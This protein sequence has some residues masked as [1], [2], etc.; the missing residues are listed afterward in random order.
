MTKTLLHYFKPH[1]KIFAADMFCAVMIALIDLVFPYVSRYS[2]YDLLPAMKYKAFFVVMALM[3]AAFA[4]RSG[5]YYIMTYWGHT[6]GVL[7][8]TDI[9]ADLFHHMQELD[10]EF[11]D[12]NRTG[13]LMSRLTSDLFDIT[14]LAHHGPEDI[15]ISLC[16]IAGSLV[17]MFMMEWRLALVI[18][19]L[20]PIF[21]IVLMT[22]RRDMENTSVT[23]KKKQAVISAEIES[24]I[25]GIRTSK[26]FANEEVDEERFDDSNTRYGRAKS[27]YYKAM[28]RFNASQ[29]FFM[30]AIQVAVIAFGG[31]LI[32]QEKMNYIDLITFMLY[33]STFV[34]P[35]RRLSNLADVLTNGRAGLKRFTEIMKIQPEIREKEDAKPLVVT[36]G[37][38]DIDDVTFS[39]NGKT[40]VIKDMTLH[41]RPGETLAIVG[42]SGGGKTT[43]CQL[44]PRFY[45]VDKGSIRIDGTDIRDVTKRSIRENVGIVQQD[46]FIFA[47]TVRENIRY[48]RPEATEEEI[49]EAARRAEIYDDIMRMPD[50]FDTY[51]GERG[52]KLS[53]GQKQRISIARIFLKDPK[54]LILDEATSSLDTITERAIQQSFDELAKGR[55]SLVIA[56]RLATVINA[57]RIV[58]IDDGRIA[59]EGTHRELMALNGEYARLYNTQKLYD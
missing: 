19:I 16:T 14:E 31:A 35:I 26:A 8:E 44:I 23:V 53:G 15:V 11:Y 45:D 25:S 48:G 57:D 37:A 13:V 3:V 32:M 6:F 49:D 1:K 33:I 29:E 41:V 36:D 50:G 55:T 38:I 59:E 34:T 56:H 20:V 4:M 39:Y 30:C 46:V 12:Q 22:S 17:F 43:L 52:T 47:D 40:D 51:V 5:F 58:L 10:F 21:I 42:H 28:G 18:A 9:R 2:M 7:V 24:C 27:D 54:I